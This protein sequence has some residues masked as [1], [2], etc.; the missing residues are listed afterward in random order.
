MKTLQQNMAELCCSRKCIL[1]TNQNQNNAHEH[2]APSCLT[3]LQ[4]SRPFFVQY[5]TVTS[6][7]P[8]FCII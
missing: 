5:A 8:R 1:L 7:Y 6:L 3:A 4:G 2:N